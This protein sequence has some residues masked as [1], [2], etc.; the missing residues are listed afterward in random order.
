MPTNYPCPRRRIFKTG[1][2]MIGLCSC[3]LILDFFS[4]PRIQFPILLVLPV[5]ISGWN[6]GARWAV[7]LGISLPLAR[8][9]FH[10]VWAEPFTWPYLILNTVIRACVLSGIGYL[11]S[12][13]AAQVR[14]LKVLRG[15]V[16]I[17]SHCKKI[18]SNEQHW[19]PVEKYVSDR[20]E[21]AFSHT[22]C[23]DCLET[24]YGS[25]AKELKSQYKERK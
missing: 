18:R 16:P 2:F 21:A 17:C 13:A 5:V 7:S 4:G 12:Q 22:I 6:R 20:S 8:I 10:L 9:A 14:E 23:P 25:V 15:L 3:I 24:H 19:I 11:V 1:W